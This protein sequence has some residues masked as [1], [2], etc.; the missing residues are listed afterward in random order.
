MYVCNIYIY[1]YIYTHIH[2]HILV[3]SSDK[4]RGDPSLL[5]RPASGA[6][7]P[8][9]ALSTPRILMSPR[10]PRRQHHA[11]LCFFC[12]ARERERERENERERPVAARRPFSTMIFLWDPDH[13]SPGRLARSL[14]KKSASTKQVCESAFCAS[15]PTH[16]SS[17][18]PSNVI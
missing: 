13:A 2:I 5:V 9:V 16:Q 18:L 1:I 14:G 7:T 4:W 6:A 17:G 10:G 8:Q 12:S 15:L 3:N 11:E